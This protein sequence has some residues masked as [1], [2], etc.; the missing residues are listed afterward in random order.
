M[1]LAYIRKLRT[2]HWLYQYD[3]WL[4]SRGINIEND[5]YIELLSNNQSSQQ[6]SNKYLCR[7]P[8]GRHLPR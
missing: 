1:E 4:T 8:R 3:L 6:I 5:I 2:Y 7:L